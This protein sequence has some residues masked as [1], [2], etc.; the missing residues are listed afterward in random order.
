M[1]V[2]NLT[3]EKEQKDERRAKDGTLA[4]QVYKT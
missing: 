1:Q 3:F 4:N 2:I